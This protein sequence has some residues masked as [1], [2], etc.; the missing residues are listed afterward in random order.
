MS[1]EN[2]Y[3]TKQQKSLLLSYSG[4]AQALQEDF[5]NYISL[6]VF[7]VLGIFP[8]NRNIPRFDVSSGIFGSDFIMCIDYR[9]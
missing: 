8:K 7:T 1:H 5:I 4:L 3:E 6:C 9:L 2:L